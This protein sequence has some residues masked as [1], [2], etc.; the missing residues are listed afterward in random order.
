MLFVGI[1][2]AKHKHDISILDDSGEILKSHM[3]IQN[4]RD[5]FMTL[6]QS[7]KKLSQTFNEEIMLAMEDTGIYSMNLLQFLQSKHYMVHTY[8]PLL[9]KE[10]AKANSLRKTKTDQKDALTIA[11]RCFLDRKAAPP[12]VDPVMASL[13]HLTRHR[14]RIGKMQAGLKI[15]YTRLLDLTFPELSVCLSASSMHLKYVYAMLSAYPSVTQL[16]DAHLTRLISILKQA[17]KGR[18]GKARA[19]EIR[20][21]ARTSIG[22]VSDSLS[23]ELKHLIQAIQFYEQLIQE[24][25]QKIQS[26]MTDIQSPILTIPGISHRL[27][28]IILAEVRAIEHFQS[29]AQLLAFCGLEPS[30]HQSG[31]FSG[32]GKM[33]KRGSPT[34]RWA[35]LQAAR[36]I[37]MRSPVFKIY[38]RKKLEE[39][40]H[41]N[42]AISHV[43][44]KLV[45]VLFYLLKSNQTFDESKL[46]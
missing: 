9:I 35:I 1:D 19:L 41:Y 44:K 7:L 6:H 3:R 37:A 17:S 33:V 8:N 13:K 36:L 29:P 20:D 15:Q 11:Y 26:I 10:F 46:V 22:A 45:R 28:S 30:V 34:L 42:V 40:K 39:G 2:I 43:A 38:L 27:G 4:N 16:A 31:A 18:V 21:L 12:K 25:N 5:G 32:Q 14:S 24:T 23:F